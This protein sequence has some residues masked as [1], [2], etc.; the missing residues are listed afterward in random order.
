[1]EERSG[2][3]GSS[4]MAANGSPRGDELALE[5]NGARTRFE[6]NVGCPSIRHP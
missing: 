3:H 5:A 4:W 1:M 6:I 2:L